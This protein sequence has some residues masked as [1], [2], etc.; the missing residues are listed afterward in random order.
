[1]NNLKYWYVALDVGMATGTKFLPNS[2][3][4]PSREG[5]QTREIAAGTLPE[6][7]K[8]QTHHR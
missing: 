7:T 4:N 8:A 3:Q 5:P 6:H 1:M 2:C